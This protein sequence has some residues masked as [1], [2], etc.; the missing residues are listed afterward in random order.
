MLQLP[1][2]E[3]YCKVIEYYDV[4]PIELTLDQECEIPKQ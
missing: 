3:K 4:Q 2:N 1:L